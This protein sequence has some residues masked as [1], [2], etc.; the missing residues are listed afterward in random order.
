MSRDL[1]IIIILLQYQKELSHRSN[2][3][4]VISFQFILAMATIINY[5]GFWG[6]WRE[7]VYFACGK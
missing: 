6:I 1:F 7:P 4:K 2:S 3:H 5:G